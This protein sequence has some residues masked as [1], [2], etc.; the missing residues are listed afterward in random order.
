MWIAVHTIRFCFAVFM[1]QDLKKPFPCVLCSNGALCT[2]CSR[3]GGTAPTCSTSTSP[4]AA[5]MG[6][7][8]ARRVLDGGGGDDPAQGRHLV[9][10]HG[11]AHSLCSP[12]LPPISSA[13]PVLLNLHQL[14]SCT[15]DSTAVAAQDL[16]VFGRGSV[17][18]THS[19]CLFD[20]M[21]GTC[22]DLILDRSLPFRSLVLCLYL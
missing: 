8:R 4:T 17:S 12:D 2:R 16:F 10:E 14:I 18:Q 20:K 3:S 22:S 11:R 1:P 21:A 15:C 9:V 19:I 5:A 6:H 7:G 13:W